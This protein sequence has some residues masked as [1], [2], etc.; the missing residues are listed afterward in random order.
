MLIKII[1]KLRILR[2]SHEEQEEKNK[3]VMILQRT[4]IIMLTVV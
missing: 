4:Y 2:Y 3:L 1:T